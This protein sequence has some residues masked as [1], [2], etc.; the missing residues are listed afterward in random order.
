MTTEQ[1]NQESPKVDAIGRLTSLRKAAI[2]MIFAS[3]PTTGSTIRVNAEGIAL[4]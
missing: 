1:F 2:D 4:C 3:L